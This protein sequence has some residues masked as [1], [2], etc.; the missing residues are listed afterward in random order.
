MSPVVAMTLV[1]EQLLDGLEVARV[2]EQPLAGR[3]AG[4]VHPLA[5]RRALG[6]DPG[7][8]EAAIPPV[9]QAV[10]AHRLVGERAL[11][12]RCPS[13]LHQVVVALGFGVEDQPLEV[14]PERRV[15]DRHVA[16]LAALREDRQPLADVVEVLERTA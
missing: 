14:V 4:L 9:V 7:V 6:D 13:A 16:D 8:R 5:A 11:R 15:G 10:V 1:A 3:V 12:G 2:I